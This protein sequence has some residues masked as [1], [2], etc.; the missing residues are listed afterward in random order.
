M[1]YFRTA[2]NQHRV[3]NV[4]TGLTLAVIPTHETESITFQIL[5]TQGGIHGEI[6][7]HTGDYYKLISELSK[8]M[9]VDKNV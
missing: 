7:L 6:Q 9:K 5:G 2:D 8:E 4:R 1:A 3:M